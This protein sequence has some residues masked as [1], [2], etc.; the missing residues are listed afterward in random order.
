MENAATG[1]DGQLWWQGVG[2]SAGEIRTTGE[3]AKALYALVI[4]EAHHKLVI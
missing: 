4:D 3:V 2:A 1:G